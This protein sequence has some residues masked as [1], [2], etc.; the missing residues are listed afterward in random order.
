MKE[1][2]CSLVVVLNKNDIT[3]ENAIL[4]SYIEL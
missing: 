2:E 3:D 1:I 4:I